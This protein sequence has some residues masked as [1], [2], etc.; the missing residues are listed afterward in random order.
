MPFKSVAQQH[1]LEMM[2]AKYPRQF[3]F[4]REFEKATPSSRYKTLPIKL[5][6][7]EHGGVYHL[8]G[9]GRKKYHKC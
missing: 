3:K 6:I 1:Y 9:S 8:T 2:R 5:H 7:G 4:V